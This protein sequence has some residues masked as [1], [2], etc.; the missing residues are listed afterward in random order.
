MLFFPSIYPKLLKIVIFFAELQFDTNCIYPS[1]L[2][3]ACDA[4]KIGFQ[5]L[6]FFGNK[7]SVWSDIM[8]P[9]LDSPKETYRYFTSD[10][11]SSLAPF[12]NFPFVPNAIGW[13]RG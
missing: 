8:N 1:R 4:R 2:T 11:Y 5:I 6:R 7:A 10:N 13:R 12:M 3:V 9:I